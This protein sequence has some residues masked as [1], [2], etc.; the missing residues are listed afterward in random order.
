MG[1]RVVG[2]FKLQYRHEEVEKQEAPKK[3]TLS[4]I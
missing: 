1:I 3:K 2:I 4:T